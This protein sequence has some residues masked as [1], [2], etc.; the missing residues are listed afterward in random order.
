MVLIFC[1]MILAGVLALVMLGSASTLP[2]TSATVR[3]AAVSIDWLRPDQVNVPRGLSISTHAA[4]HNG[5]VERLYWLLA[6]GQ[7]MTAAKFCGGSE[8]ERLYTCVDPITGLVGAILQFGDEI[9]T[10]YFERGGSD[11]WVKRVAREKWEVCK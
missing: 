11:Y 5:E 2:V 6:Q 3:Q 8:V 9:T 10:G 4:E 7:C 1:M